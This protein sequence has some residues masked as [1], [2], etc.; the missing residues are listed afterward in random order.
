MM[1]LPHGAGSIH[2]K[3]TGH[4]NSLMPGTGM[5]V[6]DYVNTLNYQQQYHYGL[7]VLKRFGW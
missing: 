3:V 6:R 2:K 1:K 7:D 5:R 4:Y